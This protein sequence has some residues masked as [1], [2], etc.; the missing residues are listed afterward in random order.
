MDFEWDGDKRRA[1]IAKHYIDFYDALEVFGGPYVDL[2]ARSDIEQRRSA[3][4]IVNGR[5]ATVIY[6]L[7][8]D[9][10]RL[11]TARRARR[12][13]QQEYDARYRRSGAEDA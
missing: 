2:P 11:I 8:G 6:A 5:V 7:R 1:V 10:I 4:G 12:H 13:E 9:T 3:I